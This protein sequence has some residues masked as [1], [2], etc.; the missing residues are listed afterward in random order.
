MQRVK[1]NGIK[2]IDKTGTL[3]FLDIPV[4]CLPPLM[5]SHTDELLSPRDV[6]EWLVFIGWRALLQNAVDGHD[7]NSFR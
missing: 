6:Q 4:T 3:P 1:K 7:G 2:E 5:P